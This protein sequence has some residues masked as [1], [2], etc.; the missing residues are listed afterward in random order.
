MFMSEELIFEGKKFIA[1]AAAAATFG[2]TR[3][4]L[5]PTR[6]TIWWLTLH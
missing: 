3:A 5:M 2:F 6:R 4:K 1:A